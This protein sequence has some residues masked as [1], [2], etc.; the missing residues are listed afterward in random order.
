[1][2]K[3]LCFLLFLLCSSAVRAEIPELIEEFFT[4][5]NAFP[6]EKNELEFE[7]TV[8][9]AHVEGELEEVRSALGTFGLTKRLQM[10]GGFEWTRSPEDIQHLRNLELAVF[11]SAIQRAGNLEL[12]IGAS[13]SVPTNRPGEDPGLQ[14]ETLLVFGHQVGDGQ[15]HL[16]LRPVLGSETSLN[17]GAGYVYPWEMF[18]ATLELSGSAEES[19][20]AFAGGI[21]WHPGG[22]FEAG[23]CVQRGL[24][25]KTPD[26]SV[27]FKATF[28]ISF[29]P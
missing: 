19:Q 18:R 9:R 20:L 4:T 2:L 24:T 7:T 6:H 25:R 14:M 13:A 21:Y 15:I 12:D 22:G 17:A 27:I 8:S 23:A 29:P 11:Y 28:E 3:P 10:E 1:M 5:E 26:W 16:T